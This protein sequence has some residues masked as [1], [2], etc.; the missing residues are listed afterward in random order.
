M[1]LVCIM[2]TEAQEAGETGF[3]FSLELEK[4]RRQVFKR[5]HLVFSFVNVCWADN[6][7]FWTQCSNHITRYAIKR[8][9]HYYST[10]KEILYL[11]VISVIIGV[12]QNLNDV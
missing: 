8:H 7:E 6:M 3:I 5:N 11:I 12:I 2:E 1:Q 4:L 10:I 9:T